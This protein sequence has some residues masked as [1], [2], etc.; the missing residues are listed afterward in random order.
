[1]FLDTAPVCLSRLP[2]QAAVPI[3]CSRPPLPPS[4]PLQC[5]YL[6]FPAAS[7]AFCPSPMFLSAVPGCKAGSPRLK[8]RNCL[9][10]QI[11]PLFIYIL[12]KEPKD[13]AAHCRSCHNRSQIHERIADGRQY[14]DASMG[15]AQCTAKCHGKPACQRGTDDTGWNDAQRILCGKGNGS[16]R[17]EGQSHDIVYNAGLAVLC[18]ELIN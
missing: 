7:P 14:K 11:L 18:R 2:S 4:V 3:C 10:I 13:D 9:P 6:L 1:M 16:L 5:S 8:R 15:C 12:F 17:D